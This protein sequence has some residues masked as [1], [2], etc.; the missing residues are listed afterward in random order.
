MIDCQMPFLAPTFLPR[1][2]PLENFSKALAQ[3]AVKGLSPALGNA[4]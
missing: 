4:A 3:L 1:R 2:K